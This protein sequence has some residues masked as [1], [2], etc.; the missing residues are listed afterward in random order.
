[1]NVLNMIRAKEVKAAAR[2]AAFR[3]QWIKAKEICG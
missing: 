2:Q 1:M 3:A